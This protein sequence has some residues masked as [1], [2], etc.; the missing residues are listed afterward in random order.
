MGIIQNRLEENQFS[1]NYLY[2]D[3]LKG[4][5]VAIINCGK[6]RCSPFIFRRLK[7]DEYRKGVRVVVI[8]GIIVEDAAFF[9][10]K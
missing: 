9:V 5:Y 4:H 2:S 3:I 1:L 7:M 6:I 8:S 10:R